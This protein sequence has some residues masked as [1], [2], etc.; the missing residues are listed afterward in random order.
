MIAVSNLRPLLLT[1]ATNFAWIS[2]LI[3]INT[4]LKPLSVSL[5]T[6]HVYFLQMVTQAHFKEFIIKFV[7]GVGVQYNSA[8]LVP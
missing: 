5:D 8:C 7:L 1:N 3:I 2:I 6:V 4:A